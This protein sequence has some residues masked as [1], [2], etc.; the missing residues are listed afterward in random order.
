[1]DN[2]VR[3]VLAGLAL[4]VC[5]IFGTAC[6]GSLFGVAAGTGF[7]ACAAGF[8][9]WRLMLGNKQEPRK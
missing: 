4:V 9:A 7:L 8:T 5:A 3:L 6:V 1:M 2:D